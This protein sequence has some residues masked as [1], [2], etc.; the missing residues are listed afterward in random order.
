MGLID[1]DKLQKQREEDKTKIYLVLSGDKGFGVDSSLVMKDTSG[2]DILVTGYELYTQ[3]VDRLIGNRVRSG[4]DVDIR[5]GNNTGADGLAV[6]Y[7][8]EHGYRHHQYD[9]SWDKAG[10]SAMYKSIEN[11]YLMIGLKDHKG[12]FL[13]WD[14]EDKYTRYM[15][16]C[17]WAQS[18]PV[19]V[20]N[21]IT[22][23]WLSQEKIKEVQMDVRQE[24]TKF[25]R[26]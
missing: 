18:V 21:Y 20:W 10:A 9:P 22:K 23:E 11:M 19:R 5:H 24:Q 7:S 2:N 26:Y 6:K 14:G 8:I 12:S 13:L 17:A 15:M 16:F 3:L 25:G 4:F 1:F